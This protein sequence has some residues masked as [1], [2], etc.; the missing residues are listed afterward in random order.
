MC[1]VAI[2]YVKFRHGQMAHVL[3]LSF[4]LRRRYMSVT[5]YVRVQNKKKY[6]PEA[7]GPP[8]KKARKA[9]PLSGGASDVAKVSGTLGTPWH[10][11][12]AACMHQQ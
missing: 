5:Q 12:C 3:L 11:V 10:T 7:D 8:R 1:L 6:A 4:C 2:R 9:R